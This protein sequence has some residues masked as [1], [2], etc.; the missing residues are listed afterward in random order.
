MHT[1]IWQLQKMTTHFAFSWTRLFLASIIFLFLETPILFS[2][3]FPDTIKQKLSGMDESAQIK[4]LS[5]LC[6]DLRDE[7]NKLSV[8]CGR[9][10][11]KLAEKI[12][13]YHEIAQIN[14]Y[15]G[16]GALYY[17]F[18]LKLALYYFEIGFSAAQMENDTI[19][20]AY[21][22]N[23]I[24]DVYFLSGNIPLASAYADSS[25]K[26]FELINFSP[27]LAY[28]YI[29]LGQVYRARSQYRMAL[30]NF[31][32]AIGL[33]AKNGIKAGMS[34]AN[35]EAAKTYILMQQYD[36]ALLY[37]N[38]SLTLTEELQNK[39]YHANSHT[40]V[41]QIHYKQKKYKE[42]LE[43]FN[44]ALQLTQE[45]ESDYGIINN[46]IGRALVYS[47]I[48]K[49]REGLIELDLASEAA[50]R[51]GLISKSMDVKKARVEFYENIGELE[52]SL[53]FYRHMIADY[54][55]L[56]ILNQFEILSEFQN[57]QSISNDLRLVS[58][59]LE[60]ERKSRIYFIVILLLTFILVIVLF[61][62]YRSNRKMNKELKKLNEGKDKLFSII[63]HDLRNP[64]IAI[65]NLVEVLKIENI[66]PKDKSKFIDHLETSTNNTYSLLE[67][68]LNL[69]AFK[70]GKIEFNPK[71]V[72]L[73]RLLSSHEKMLGT[74]L[75]SKNIQLIIEGPFEKIYA[76]KKMMEVILNNLLSNAIKY[77]NKGGRIWVKAKV[78]S[79]YYAISVID[80]GVGMSNEI[81]SKMFQS[82]LS[83]VELGTSGEKGT[84]IG[85]GLCK[86]FIEKHGGTIE[87]NS[88][89]GMG[90]E[91]IINLPLKRS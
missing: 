22:F 43:N 49:E 51:L 13:D 62:R 12:N 77:S 91:F 14:N 19:E 83:N 82:V 31:D 57:H 35:L 59:E 28:T 71:E 40:I 76:D 21:T 16:I 47:M 10:A 32:L 86:E 90:S 63:S 54:D 6:W 11:L 53:M 58:F 79:K 18:N 45:R 26:Y 9:Y 81:K 52:T 48:G 88:T 61:L 60:V 8:S 3:E 87:L 55:S 46:R 17:N 29:N 20:L 67:N 89:L 4:Y 85:L 39:T 72:S 44:E 74:Q 33:H 66:V 38:Q 25:L 50:S 69:S 42:A 78:K 65:M 30:K 70:T 5:K 7:D 24:G 34:A 75:I 15:L 27:G 41:G 23:N 36:S 64:F 84:G 56:M 2:Q 68:L 37:F 80:E 1:K 73:N